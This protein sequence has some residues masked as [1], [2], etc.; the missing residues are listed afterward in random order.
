MLVAD[1]RR[2]HPPKR[3]VPPSK[4]AG[5]SRLQRS[6]R[7]PTRAAAACHPPHCSRPTALS[8]LAHTF[9]VSQIPI[10]ECAPA[11]AYHRPRVP[12]LAAFGRRPVA[13]SAINHRRHPKPCTLA[14]IGDVL[15]ATPPRLRPRRRR[16]A[17]RWGRKKERRE[18]NPAKAPPGGVLSGRPP[19]RGCGRR[20]PSA[21][22]A[23][24]YSRLEPRSCHT[25][26]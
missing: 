3:A 17:W 8:S 24:C 23:F 22:Q 10:A 9:R 20:G 18:K 25:T 19:A 5:N 14:V 11:S 16:R 4:Q 1:R 7:S 2:P 15:R 21:R 13:R 12:S 26:D 6:S